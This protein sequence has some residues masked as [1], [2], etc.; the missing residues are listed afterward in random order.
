MQNSSVPKA[1]HGPKKLLLVDD[2]EVF[3]KSIKK[4][5]EKSGYSVVTAKNGEEARNLFPLENVDAVI[6][7]IH[8]PGQ[9]SG[10]EL[11]H[12]VKKTRAVP[13]ILMTGFA[14]LAETREAH[15]MGV[16]GFLAKPFNA[17]D[18]EKIL[19]GF[20]GVQKAIESP[21]QDES[22]KYSKIA[23]DEFISGKQIKYSI[24]IRLSDEKF[25]C[26]GHQGE[27][28]SPDRI[29][30]FKGK[31]IHHLYLQN[32]DFRKYMYFNLELSE[33]IKLSPTIPKEKKIAVVKHTA[34]VIVGHIY[35]KDIDEETFESA[36]AAV[37]TTVNF[38]ADSQATHDLLVSLNQH[39][40]AL[41]AHCVGV[42]TYAAMMCK[43]IGWH[44]PKT[45]Y[46]VTMGGLLH[47]IGKKE[48]SKEI[49]AKSRS[50]LSAEETQFLETHPTRGLEILSRLPGIPMDILQIIH[51]HHER[52]LG[53]GYPSGLRKGKIHPLARL[54]A[55]ADEFCYWVIK[56]PDSPGLPP[57]EALRRLKAFFG[58]ALDPGH[59]E[60]LCK[61][62]KVPLE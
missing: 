28:L 59:V 19:E 5:L 58:T 9:V 21:R 1:S 14:T 48:I 47:D 32:D 12:F 51:E 54:I 49:L 4:I 24:F 50:A 29:R 2:D 62:F 42:S 23:I 56:G 57:Q 41:Y 6:S 26:V 15:N 52:D 20:F 3:C 40:D 13:V 61:V 10:I 30:L 25:V 60:A 27:D 45:I 37:E 18:L 36:R 44:S 34:E 55:V 16:A 46:K 8:M 53:N 43:K 38:L 35:S 33:K 17:L 31:G 11:F 22:S 39:S 7:D